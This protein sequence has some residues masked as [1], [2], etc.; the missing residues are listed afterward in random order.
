M[1]RAIAAFQPARS[2]PEKGNPPVGSS[3]RPHGA[4]MAPSSET[5]VDAISFLTGRLLRDKRVG[6]ISTTNEVGRF[7]HVGRTIGSRR[8]TCTHHGNTRSAVE[9]ME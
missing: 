5:M 8:K 3:P 1:A 9:V 4:C 2:L 6:V 7:R